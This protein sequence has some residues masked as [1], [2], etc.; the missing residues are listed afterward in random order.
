MQPGFV[1]IQMPLA[2]DCVSMRRVFAQGSHETAGKRLL[3]LPGL[4]LLFSM[5]QADSMST[6]QLQNRPAEEVIPIVKPMLEAGDAISGQGFKIFLRSSPETAARVRDMIDALD[7]PLRTLQ[8]SVFQGSERDLGELGMSTRI[9]I[10]TG[11][12]RIDVGHE[13][14]NKADASGSVTYGTG[15]GRAGIHGTSTQK[16]LRDNPKVLKR[17]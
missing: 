2:V 17:T 16:S 9:E 6:I 5:V 8:V 13:G 10:E 3:G 1:A 7:T 14:G 12:A 11:D 4:V 15:K